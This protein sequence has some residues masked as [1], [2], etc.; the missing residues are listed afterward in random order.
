MSTDD[1]PDNEPENYFPKVYDT[2]KGGLYGGYFD[3]SVLDPN[4]AALI[5]DYRWTTSY[6]GPTAATTMTYYFPQSASDYH[7][8]PSPNLINPVQNFHPMSAVQEAAVLTSFALISSY[9][10]VI[11]EEAPSGSADHA[12][13]RFAGYDKG[14]SEARF[15]SNADIYAQQQNRPEYAPSDSRDAGD[16]FLG[17]NGSPPG[18][19]YFGT[20][21]FNTIMHEL[22]HSIGLKHG[23]DD[24]LHGK[25]AT[26]FD[27]NEFSVMTYASYFGA[28]TGGATEARVG[29][30]PQSY[31]MFDIAALQALYGANFSKIGSEAVYKWDNVTGQQYINDKVA[32]GT[33]VTATQKIFATVWTQGAT[34]TYDLRNFH[35]DQVDDLRP[36][37]WLTFSHDQ[38]ADLNNAVDAGTAEFMAQGNIYNALQYQNDQHSL[39]DNLITG[40]GNDKIWGND[41]GN[42]ITA[43]GGND[44]IHGGVGDDVI[45]GGLGLDLIDPGNGYDTVRDTLAGLNGDYVH[46]FSEYLSVQYVGLRI[47]LSQV[48]ITVDAQQ[49]TFT[50]GGSALGLEGVLTGGAY[51][52]TPRGSGDDMYTVVKFVPYLPTLEEGHRVFEDGIN[53][54]INRAYLT[55]DGAVH[56]TGTLE[57]AVSSMSNSLG[58]Y[59]IGADGTIF[60]VHLLFA[61]THNPG[62]PTFDLGTPGNG[63]QLGFFLIQDGFTKYGN[64]ADNLSFVSPDTLGPAKVGDG[65]TLLLRSSTLGVLNGAT[66]FHTSSQLNPGE[67]NQ[68]LSGTDAAAHDLWIGFEDLLASTGDNDFQDAVL[69]IHAN[70]DALYLV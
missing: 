58:V 3:G 22:G 29:S 14:G 26:Q 11:F 59:K 48:K 41:K 17:T 40:D 28:D 38:L 23:H 53:G 12:T 21:Q 32:P 60:D 31:M 44:E 39:I 52:A 68:M 30:S 13:F 43:N 54:I 18:A 51:M 19:V 36:G 70:A 16:N 27:D 15:P 25:L 67:H 20:D 46:H 69:R 64:L 6:L 33:G 8:S 7:I 10:G 37:H 9:T 62:S 63:V 56:L 5:M 24:S 55:G 47:G 45:T 2:P 42:H 1:A 49:T 66:V 4:V 65:D 57:A 34:S 50:V 61:N 35:Q